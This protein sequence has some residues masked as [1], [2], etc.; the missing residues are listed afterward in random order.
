MLAGEVQRRQ[1]RADALRRELEQH[2]QRIATLECSLSE[3][4]HEMEGF[5]TRIA[6]LDSA[7]S[8][9]DV[10]V[11]PSALGSVKATSE[12]YGG[13]GLLIQYLES[14]VR[15]AGTEGVDTV[16][17]TRRAASTFGIPIEHPVDL[18][19][20]SHTIRS[21]LRDLRIKGLI[22]NDYVSQ[23]DRKPSIWRVRTDA[24]L[25]DELLQQRAAIEGA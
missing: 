4:Q 13:R 16:Q 25:F 14:E 9:V 6:A 2:Q 24:G 17:L 19:L 3:L 1:E 23:K 7:I 21:T 15:A 22:E 8:M 18:R 12:R 10:R 20:Y 11:N 5:A